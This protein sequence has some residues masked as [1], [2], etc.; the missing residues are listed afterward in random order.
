VK[1]QHDA[2]PHPDNAT[3]NGARGRQLPRIRTAV[4]EVFVDRFAGPAGAPLHNTPP[5]EKPWHHHCGGTL[6]GIAA[7]IDH[8]RTL[9]ADAV[10]LTPIFS[11]PSNHKYDASSYE[12][13]EQ[14]FG[15]DAAFDHLVRECR[16]R[17]MGLIL[18]GVFNH[19][20]VEHQWF[21]EAKTSV[22]AARRD[23]FKWNGHPHGYE[24]WRGHS[25]LPELNLDS[26]HVRE[27]LFEG[28]R[29]IIRHWLQ[30]GATGWRLDC[31]ND[32]GMD[33]CALATNAAHAENPTDGV[34]G[35][36]MTYAED[37]LTQGD[38]D[39]V[40]NYYFRETALALAKGEIPVAQAAYNFKRMA[41]RYPY[42]K[43]LRSWNMLA[44]HDTPRLAHEIPDRA[45]RRFAQVLQYA[46]PGTPMIY[47]GEEIGMTGGHDPDCRRPMV[48]DEHKQDAQTLAL[49]QQLNALRAAHP[50]LR[51]GEYLPLPQPGAPAVL[52]FART[53]P[54][55]AEQVIVVANASDES[56][57]ARL[58]TPYAYLFDSLKLR[59]LLETEGGT[60]V[61][62]GSIRPKLGP[63]GIALYAPDDSIPGYTF[64]R[65]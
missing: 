3:H 33:M 31:A 2:Q 29:A 1:T 12:H 4:Y 11:A 43:L 53:M 27:A 5:R 59:D 14:R 41:R 49:L 15:G 8:I 42:P 30:R 17:D 40:M 62:A 23:H 58:F 50:A 44:S 26:P 51:H 39:G 32:L 48:W 34:L 25:T 28:E 56:F 16:Q 52:A 46:F 54:N 20:G 7:R 45:R 60:Q 24:C 19:V 55:P 47:Y 35:E 36:I 61:V 9:G 10:Y 64:F 6:D 18:D 57:D 38:L 63:W 22:A 65:K 21:S 13:I 37:W